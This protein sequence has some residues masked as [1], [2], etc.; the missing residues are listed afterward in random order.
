MSMKGLLGLA[1]SSCLW[2][3]PGCSVL[4]FPRRIEDLFFPG[5]PLSSFVESRA[6][7]LGIYCATHIQ[8][9]DGSSGSRGLCWDSDTN[10][11]LFLFSLW[12]FDI[13]IPQTPLHHCI[14][15]AN[16]P[17]RS[18]PKQ[19]PGSH[20]HYSQRMGLAWCLV[21]FQFILSLAPTQELLTPMTTMSQ[22]SQ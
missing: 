9:K 14:K 21:A 4:P 12:L 5:F 20:R 19:G 13:R 18:W 2:L 11:T 17:S 3:L 10:H 16:L 22:S 8:F 1:L 7:V 6:G 15:P